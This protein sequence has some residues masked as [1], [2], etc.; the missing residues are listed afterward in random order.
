MTE[1]ISFRSSYNKIMQHL[2]SVDLILAV[3]VYSES[4]DC[5]ARRDSA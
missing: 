1:K 5:G 4:V 3:S 2:V